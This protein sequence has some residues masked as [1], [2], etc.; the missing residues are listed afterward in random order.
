MT[1]KRSSICKMFAD[2]AFRKNVFLICCYFRNST[3]CHCSLYLILSR[4]SVA[5][6]QVNLL[7]SYSI[8]KDWSE[9]CFDVLGG[10]TMNISF[11]LLRPCF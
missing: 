3:Q 8:L 11:H 9:V 5:W 10:K 6:W 1:N 7:S 4:A 2:I